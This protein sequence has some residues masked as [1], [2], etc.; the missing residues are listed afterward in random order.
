MDLQDFKT[1]EEYRT[2]SQVGGLLDKLDLNDPGA[3]VVDSRSSIPS[4]MQSY[5]A[6]QAQT[7]EELIRFMGQR[8]SQ[9]L[10]VDGVEQSVG[11]QHAALSTIA[12]KQNLLTRQMEKSLYDH[13]NKQ[14]GLECEAGL[15]LI[16]DPPMGDVFGIEAKVSDSGLRLITPFTGDSENNEN[17]LNFFLREV[18]TL[19][20]TS[21]LTE[22]ATISVVIRKVAGSAQ[23]LLDDFVTQQGGPTKL[24]LKQVVGHLERKFI[25]Q[26]SPL[27]ADAKLHNLTQ[28]SLSYSQLQAKVQ[29]LVKLACRLE[30]DDRRATLVKVKE[31]SAFL[32]A[33]STADRLLINAENSRR[34]NDNLSALSLDQMVNFLAKAQ[35]DKMNYKESNV[36]TVQEEGSN[37]SQSFAGPVHYIQRGN[38]RGRTRPRGSFGQQ[39]GAYQPN[40]GN[41]QPQR[42]NFQPQRGVFQQQRGTVRNGRFQRN[43]NNVRDRKFVTCEMANVKQN[44]CILCGDETHLF[45]DSK[46]I[47]HGCDLMH[48]PCRKCNTG[49]H[50]TILCQAKVENQPWAGQR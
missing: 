26:S 39:R 13:L 25:I 16:N 19:A 5:M 15:D 48:S 7:N 23:I 35:A 14:A 6:C 30:K 50:P 29:K 21:N 31:C 22:A 36:F 27:H 33:I 2:S 37:I 40:R 28:D 49:V 3:N 46:C 20:Q 38:F 24:N 9:P 1:N 18:F 4:L 17:D 41:F 11:D 43:Q 10:Q 45:K 42:G 8:I 34:A 47:Y 12:N 32:M 44:A